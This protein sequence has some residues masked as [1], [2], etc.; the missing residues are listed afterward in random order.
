M[1]GSALLVV[2]VGAVVSPLTD[3]ILKKPNVFEWS[4]PPTYS[5]LLLVDVCLFGML[6]TALVFVARLTVGISQAK[7]NPSDPPESGLGI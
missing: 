6:V 7:A 2:L 4:I 3:D 5:G 1:I